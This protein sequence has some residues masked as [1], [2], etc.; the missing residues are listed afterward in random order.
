MQRQRL[1]ELSDDLSDC[2]RGTG[3]ED[4]FALLRLADVIETVEGRL[5]GHACCT[6]PG[7]E[8][9]AESELVVGES[10]QSLCLLL[11]MDSVLF[12]GAKSVDVFAHGKLFVLRLDD[13]AEEEIRQRLIEGE[14]GCITVFAGRSH[15]STHVRI[16]GDDEILRQ[17][18]T[19]KLDSLEIDGS[20]L[21]VFDM[22]TRDE[23]NLRHFVK[24]NCCIA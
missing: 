20:I 6:D 22:L 24:N 12:V 18:A 9:K 14:F 10:V 5:T 4:G 2:A 7:G 15:A 19:L 21:D 13:F 3:D 8:W 17:N 1:T 16:D 11:G 23:I